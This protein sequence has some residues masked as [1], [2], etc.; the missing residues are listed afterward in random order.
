M[1]NQ[2]I[3]PIFYNYIILGVFVNRGIKEEQRK[4]NH[5]CTKFRRQ[6]FLKH[7]FN[8]FKLKKKMIR[9]I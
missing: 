9:A 2:I 5:A 8:Y 6:I 3:L 4:E 1:K 7:F